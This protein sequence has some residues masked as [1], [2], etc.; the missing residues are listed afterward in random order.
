MKGHQTVGEV[1]FPVGLSLAT[2]G[3]VTPLGGIV[4]PSVG[5][6]QRTLDG[7][8]TQFVAPGEQICAF[9]Y[10]KISYRWLRSKNIDNL[11][12][13]EVPRWTAKESWRN[14]SVSEAKDEPD[15]LE[16]QTEELEQLEGD[17]EKEEGEGGET[18][19]MRSVEESDEF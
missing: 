12:L 6:H 15:V 14:A 10:C 7:A 4:D 19:L 13:S 9:Q 11:K 2:V 5:G 8:K 16:V 3:A 1:T 17:W 18:L